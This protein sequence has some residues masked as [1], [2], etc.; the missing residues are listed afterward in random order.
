MIYY[1]NY[2]CNNIEFNNEIRDASNRVS[3]LSINNKS[4]TGV[5]L[6]TLLNLRSTDFTM[7]I[8]NN[9]VKIETKGYGHGVGMSQYGANYLANTGLNYELILQYY[10]Q[11][12]EINK[13]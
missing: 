10:Y 8:E 1:A 12:V 2:S 13:Y 3:S 4:F 5:E 9:E 6:R 11:N 7:N